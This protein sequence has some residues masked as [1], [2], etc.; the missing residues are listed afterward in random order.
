MQLDKLDIERERKVVPF[1]VVVPTHGRVEL[2]LET[3]KSLESQSFSDFELVV[4]DDSN[5]PR[6]RDQIERAV[7]EYR[8]KTG[9]ITQY[10]FTKPNLGQA[11]NTNQGLAMASGSL[12]RILH[13]D[14]I[15]H[16][17]CIEWEYARFQENKDLRVLFHDCIHFDA[18][19]E[20]KWTDAPFVKFLDPYQH[21]E[22]GLSFSTALPS[23]T[24]Y[25]RSVLEAV[26]LMREDFT[27]LCDW[28]LFAKALLWCGE[29]GG[30]VINSTEG[31]VGWRVHGDSTTSRHW[32]THF[33]E[34][35]VLMREWKQSLPGNHSSLFEQTAELEDFFIKGR[36][37]NTRRAL[38]DF[39]RLNIF[40][41]I[42]YT[43]WMVRNLKYAVV[44]K[45]VFKRFLTRSRG[46]YSLCKN[47]WRRASSHS[48]NK[49]LLS[50]WGP[51]VTV[52]QSFTASDNDGC[53]Q[54]ILRRFDNTLNF[55]FSASLIREARRIRVIDINCNK[56]YARTLTEFFKYVCPGTE[57]EFVFNDNAH[58]TWFGLKSLIQQYAP[59]RFQ[60]L[61]QNISPKEGNES[62]YSAWKI[63]YL[64]VASA[65]D[66]ATKPFN[67]VTIGILTQG[68]NLT[69]IMALIKS[70]EKNCEFPYEIIV[71]SPKALKLDCDSNRIKQITVD[72]PLGYGW[73][74]RKKN[75]ICE[76]ATYNDIIVCHDR[77]RFSDQFFR[78][79]PKWGN[80]Y[81]IATPK[82]I[83]QD[84]RRA[85]DWPVVRG[86][87]HS[88]SVG[89]LLSYRDYSKFSYV[90]GGI[91]MIRKTFWEQFKWTEDIYWNEHEDVELCRRIQRS[92]H[93]IYLYP[94][95]AI[96]FRDRWIDKNPL[97][98]FNENFELDPVR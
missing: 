28:D 45:L 23:G 22:S 73:I 55:F 26:G 13:S 59:G 58:M 39:L 78:W 43:P 32:R 51:D 19:D 67:G 16:Q 37:Y 66:W 56:F 31:L 11:R 77:F 82:V 21:F 25:H 27:F 79:F 41:K 92:N 75:A 62:A 81:G 95:T 14:D 83:L 29:A 90:P 94:G 63:R 88:W 54:F 40:D 38:M 46:I 85:L 18:P 33:Q 57:V 24:V 44:F 17:F 10:V 30:A 74:T 20:I 49:G 3:I 36:N 93:I 1:S 52:S 76:L 72:E 4:T 48:V 68:E 2:F 64:C 60:L 84:G 65:P 53:K 47:F 6:E 5:S 9:R 97:I 89:G 7:A 69:E 96:T 34:H 98:E 15:I 71:S 91:T 50:S 70:V 12:I 87:N 80:A 8:K 61:W 86:E 42:I 35:E